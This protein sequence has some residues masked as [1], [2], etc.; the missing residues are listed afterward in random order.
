[1]GSAA[2][3]WF[4]RLTMRATGMAEVRTKG[5]PPTGRH[6]GEGR[7][8]VCSMLRLHPGWRRQAGVYW[9]PACAGVTIEG[10]DGLVV[11]HSHPQFLMP[12]IVMP[13]ITNF[14]ATRKRRTTG[15]MDMLMAAM[16]SDRL[17]ELR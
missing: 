9:A 4:D 13:S 5:A 1:M 15:R 14:W 6:P 8:P 10:E 11:D 17:P 12:L 2:P 7:D 16:T 3:S